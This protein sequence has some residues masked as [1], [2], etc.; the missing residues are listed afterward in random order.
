M[1][2]CANLFRSHLVYVTEHLVFTIQHANKGHISLLWEIN[3]SWDSL[4]EKQ[5]F[6]AFI[7]DI[8]VSVCVKGLEREGEDLQHCWG[9]RHGG[10]RYFHRLRAVPTFTKSILVIALDTNNDSEKIA[11]FIRT[12]PQ[13]FE[14]SV[15]LVI[16][17]RHPPTVLYSLR[18]LPNLRDTSAH[19]EVSDKKCR[20][21]T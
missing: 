19:W 16:V 15:V 20:T 17:P 3:K 1:R 18:V 6:T 14:S 7:V 5:N 9:K 8:S 4:K 13:C 10:V 2:L 12:L 11:P 21:S